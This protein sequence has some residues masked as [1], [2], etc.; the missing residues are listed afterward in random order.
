MKIVSLKHIE[1]GVHLL[2][3]YDMIISRYF[4]W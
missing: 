1:G 3:E 2:I 4:D